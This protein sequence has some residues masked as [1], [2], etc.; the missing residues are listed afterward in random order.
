VTGKVGTAATRVKAKKCA[1][2]S[3][4]IFHPFV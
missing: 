2:L 1:G 4:S 3:L